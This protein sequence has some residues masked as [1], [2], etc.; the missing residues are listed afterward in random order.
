MIEYSPVQTT[1]F[2]KAIKIKARLWNFVWLFFYK[3]TP[4]FFYKYRIFILNLFGA[5]VSYLA[6]PASS[7]FIEFPWNLTMDEYAST[8]EHSWI[9]CLDKINLGKNSCVGQFC[10]LITGSHNYSSSNFEMVTAPIIINEGCWLTNDVMVLQGITIGSYT[11]IGAR[12]LVTK[13]IEDNVIA[14]G[15]P[16]KVS[17]KRFT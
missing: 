13:D 2:S 8:G 9:Y 15:N 4:W 7:S 10:K 17:K 5:N 1:P 14:Y 11:V 3:P 12:S 16:C 6:K